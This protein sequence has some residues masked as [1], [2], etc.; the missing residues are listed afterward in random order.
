MPPP[1][2]LHDTLA[3]LLPTGLSLTLYHV[4]HN[5]IKSQP[6]YNPPLNQPLQPASLE[7]HCLAV[8]HD[9]ILCFVIE[10]LTYISTFKHPQTGKSHK[11][12]TF[13]ISKADSSGYLP[14]SAATFQPKDP[15]V[16]GMAESTLRTV[17]SIFVEHVVRQHRLSHPNIRKSTISLFARS[18][19]AYL[20][21]DSGKNPKKHVLDDRGLIRWWCRVLDPILQSFNDEGSP[22]KASAYLLVPGLDKYETAAL[23]PPKT[24]QAAFYPT[25]TR[26][27]HGHPLKVD[28]A[29]ELTVREVIPH[30]PDDPKARFLDELDAEYINTTGGSKKAAATRRGAGVGWTT[31]KTLDQFW[32][33]M[34]FRQEC[35][36]G[37]STGF[38]WI[39]IERKKRK[40]V[41]E[42][43]IPTTVSTGSQENKTD[44]L[45]DI[46]PS[47]DTCTSST[48]PSTEPVIT[49]PVSTEAAITE[50]AS[51]EPTSA[52]PQPAP[53]SYPT[54]DST[55]PKIQPSPPQDPN[56][57][58]P[59]TP[60]SSHPPTSL[61][62]SSASYRKIIETFFLSDYGNEPAARLHSR[63]WIDGALALYRSDPVSSKL[64]LPN[65]GSA[66]WGVEVVGKREVD[67]TPITAAA[68][69]F[70]G[71]TVNILPVRKKLKR[72]SDAGLVD[73]NTTATSNTTNPTAAAELTLGQGPSVVNTLDS[74]L[75][76]KK[77]K[78]GYGT[79]A[80]GPAPPPTTNRV[81]NVLAPG[82]IRKNPKD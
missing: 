11:E 38:I 53:S 72:D 82:L 28:T 57:S 81:V 17:A 32:E 13:F 3:A 16:M 56:N 78:L 67:D 55:P 79:S 62:F 54:E 2:S 37:A 9:G 18:Q 39:V 80:P 60:S 4:S 14:R 52:L 59:P 40:V 1:A 12:A 61:R 6:L 30:F 43:S 36:S 33:L 64:P 5:P 63:K 71:G 76:R 21:P 35:S 65:P 31:V 41:E 42:V 45:Q 8:S 77:P 26:W 58:T 10:V 48:E 19:S 15:A 75:M 74:S 25:A 44:T 70:G 50:S 24:R 7:T 51:T 46:N 27:V 73:N 69:G 49:E 66:D 22:D 23:F 34:S 47:N 20:F 29:R 68:H